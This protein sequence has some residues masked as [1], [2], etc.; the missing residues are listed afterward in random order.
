VLNDVIQ[1]P[2]D[3]HWKK[4]LCSCRSSPQTTLSPKSGVNWRW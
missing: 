1:H 4:N 2:T 3:E